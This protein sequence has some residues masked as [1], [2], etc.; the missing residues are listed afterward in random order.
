MLSVFNFNI[1]I[2]APECAM[3]KL[4]YI[5]KWTFVEAMPLAAAVI[6][7][8]CHVGRYLWKRLV[9]RVPRRLWN[10]HVPALVGTMFTMMYYLYLNLTR[11]VLDIFNCQR[12]NPSVDGKKYLRK[13][14]VFRYATCGHVCSLLRRGCGGAVWEAWRHSVDSDALR[15]HCVFRVHHWLP[16]CHVCCAVPEPLP[17]HGGPAVAC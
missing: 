10:A 9:A 12:L 16:R 3:P 7:L 1:D 13:W 2:T 6:F 5:N 15:H 17:D 14:D 8:L 4:N 11:S